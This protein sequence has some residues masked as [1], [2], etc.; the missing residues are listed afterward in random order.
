MDVYSELSGGRST[1]PLVP[2]LAARPERVQKKLIGNGIHVPSFA[3]FLVFVLAHSKRRS[4]FYQICQVPDAPFDDID[5]VDDGAPSDKTGRT[6]SE[7]SES[8]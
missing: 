5:D 8:D 2:L 4:D 1:S 6:K 3:N 7:H